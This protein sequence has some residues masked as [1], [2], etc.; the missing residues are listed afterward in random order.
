MTEKRSEAYLAGY[1]FGREGRRTKRRFDAV[2]VE[3]KAYAEGIVDGRRTARAA[4][5]WRKAIEHERISPRRAER[6]SR[7]FGDGGKGVCPS[8]SASSLLRAAILFAVARNRPTASPTRHPAEA[9]IVEREVRRYEAEYVNGL[10]HWDC[11]HGSRKGLCQ[12]NGG[13]SAC[14]I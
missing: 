5:E 8:G 13:S 6:L 9:H 11:H 14:G 1:F 12:S 10:W 2:G 7:Q 3:L 4:E